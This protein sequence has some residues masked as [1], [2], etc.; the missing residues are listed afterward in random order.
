LLNLLRHVIY[1]VDQWRMTFE[2]Q[3]A[4]A[5]LAYAQF[6]VKWSFKFQ[7][8]RPFYLL[9]NHFG[10]WHSEESGQVAFPI[11]WAI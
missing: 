4:K 8:H 3:R 10:S 6:V 5:R 11:L 9:P 2:P 1:D 7:S